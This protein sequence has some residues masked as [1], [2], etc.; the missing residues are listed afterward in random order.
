[1][2]YPFLSLNLRL[3]SAKSLLWAFAFVA[4]NLLLPFVCHHAPMGNL[5][6]V[7]LPIYFFTL[8][9]AYKFGWQVGLATA[10]LSPL[11]NTLLLSMP[12]VAAL[13]II[14]TKSVL[15][16]GFAALMAHYTRKIS[17]LHLLAVV[18]AYQIIGS[19]AEMLFTQSVATG[20]AEF[21]NGYL[22]MIVQVVGG[23]FV[24]KVLAKTSI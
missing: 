1:M 16:A 13:P 22:G 18:L 20:L 8:I 19:C 2:N 11:V 24:L 17:M 10:I 15:L 7:L 14:L 5:G 4:G 6:F 21:Q 3:T 12:I 23:Y 9:A